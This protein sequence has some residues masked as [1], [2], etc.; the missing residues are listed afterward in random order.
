MSKKKK[1]KRKI[2]KKM[3]KRVSKLA[4]ESFKR[5]FSELYG[6]HSVLVEPIIPGPYAPLLSEEETESHDNEDQT[7]L[8]TAADEF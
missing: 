8:S 6:S 3:I 4:K 5:L 7:A 1:L 2:E